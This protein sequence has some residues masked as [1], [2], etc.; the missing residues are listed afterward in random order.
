MKRIIK[1]I[2]ALMM[3]LPFIG[4]AIGQTHSSAT[5]MQTV[6]AS[7]AIAAKVTLIGTPN[8][9]TAGTLV[10]YSGTVT[11]TNNGASPT[12][13]VTVVG[14]TGSQ[15]VTLS[16]AGAFTCSET[17]TKVGTFT[18]TATYNGDANFF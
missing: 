7:P 11:G 14:Q 2:I 16:A 6:K 3:A 5:I 10:T 17:I 12:G 8:P 4:M 1:A 18:I 15:T 9:S 13:T